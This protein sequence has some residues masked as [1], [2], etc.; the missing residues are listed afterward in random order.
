[1]RSGLTFVSPDI[2][3][4]AN[5]L[6]PYLAP[7][8]SLYT[9]RQQRRPS[10]TGSTEGHAG[11]ASNAFCLQ[12]HQALE[13][14][15]SLVTAWS[16]NGRDSS[17]GGGGLEDDKSNRATVGHGNDKTVTRDG[18]IISTG[19]RPHSL[20]PATMQRLHEDRAFG[21]LSAALQDMLVSGH[22]PVRLISQNN[23]H[24]L[25]PIKLVEE[26][27]EFGHLIVNLSPL[28]LATH[29][30]TLRP[31]PAREQA[32]YRNHEFH[33]D[34]K[35]KPTITQDV[36]PTHAGRGQAIPKT[37]PIFKLPDSIESALKTEAEVNSRKPD[38]H[39]DHGDRSSSGSDRVT[40]TVTTLR[41]VSSAIREGLRPVSPTLAPIL[42]VF[43]LTEWGSLLPAS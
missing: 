41:G 3:L 6:K 10:P 42:G 19:D 22:G 28:L 30:T 21:P 29:Q 25:S 2:M 35:H 1:M 15:R 12:P 7:F 40:A 43:N 18:A 24:I 20:I 37:S 27:K 32:P 34:K 11:V 13:V 16:H 9:Q 23:P 8:V 39:S 26:V 31:R 17:R 36:E 33:L 4:T 38:I 14:V 5:T